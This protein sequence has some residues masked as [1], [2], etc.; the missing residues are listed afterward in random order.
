MKMQR[1]GKHN[2]F[3]IMFFLQNRPVDILAKKESV[4]V[5]IGL[6]LK[7][8]IELAQMLQSVFSTFVYIE[9]YCHI[10]FSKC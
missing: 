4:T 3:S 2:T 9:A 1:H 6:F 7:V 5:L 8:Y 10:H